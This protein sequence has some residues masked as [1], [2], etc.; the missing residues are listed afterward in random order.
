MLQLL[1]TEKTCL[2]TP[3]FQNMIQNF[4]RLH[5]KL[6]SIFLTLKQSNVQILL[7]NI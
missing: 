3:S 4:D 1:L 5:F 6:N 7:K 2:C